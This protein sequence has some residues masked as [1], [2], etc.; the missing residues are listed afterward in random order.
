MGLIFL[1]SS[2]VIHASDNTTDAG[3]AAR[4]RIVAAE[5]QFAV[6]PLVKMECLVRPIRIGDAAEVARRRDLLGG[7]RNVTIDEDAYEFAT[8]VRAIHGLS[9]PDAIHLAT[10]KFGHCD[11][12]WT[13]DSRLANAIPG[14][15]IEVSL[16]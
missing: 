15:T 13:C 1:D 6:S 14:F 7:F 3:R 4:E 12:L 10:A 16:N 11:E 5:R 8:H 9:T 2:L